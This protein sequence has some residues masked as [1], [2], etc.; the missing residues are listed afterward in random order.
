[1]FFE[2]KWVGELSICPWMRVSASAQRPSVA[3][4]KRV[5]KNIYTERRLSFF[6]LGHSV[7]SPAKRGLGTMTVAKF[8]RGCAT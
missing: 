4:E 2:H 3:Q 7:L 5:E 6:W 1:M 8:S